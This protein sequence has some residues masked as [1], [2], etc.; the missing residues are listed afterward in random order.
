MG[1]YGE[2]GGCRTGA[3]L[4]TPGLCLS[5]L[6][7]ICCCLLF[8][9]L[10]CSVL[11]HAPRPLSVCAAFDQCAEHPGLFFTRS[12]PCHVPRRTR[13]GI[14]APPATLSSLLPPHLP[15][16]RTPTLSSRRT[17]GSQTAI[18]RSPMTSLRRPTRSLPHIM[19]HGPSQKLPRQPGPSAS[20]PWMFLHPLASPSPVGLFVR[21]PA[22]PR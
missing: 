9:C 11:S 2:R 22:H 20:T 10:R 19:R 1:G 14:A 8:P 17:P 15:P 5:A 7:C 18:R 4:D 6:T 13:R 16:G 3:R 12:V 21:P